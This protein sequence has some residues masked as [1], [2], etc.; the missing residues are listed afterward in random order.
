MNYQETIQY[1]YQQLPAY[2]RIGKAAYK[3]DLETTLKLDE[4]FGHPH[5]LFKTIHVAGTNGKGSTSHMIASVLQSA[6]YKVGLYTSPHLYDFRERIKINGEMITEQCVVDFVKNHKAIIDE[7]KPSF[8]EMT[9]AMAFEYFAQQK[10][11][12]AVIEVGMGGR[13]DS[14]NIIS[15]LL[16][17]ITNIGLDHTE[18]LGD[19]VEKVAAEKAGIIK[20]TTP[21]VIGEWNA[22]SATVFTQK[23]E[24]QNAP[25]LFANKD[26]LVECANI[27]DAKQTFHIKAVQPKQFSFDS[28]D[29]QIDLLGS[30]QKNNILTVLAAIEQLKKTIDIKI[31]NAALLNGLANAAQQ[32]GLQ[33]RWQ[34]LQTNPAIIADTGHNAHGLQYVMAQLKSMPYN[35]LYMV[36]GVVS[37]KDVDSILPLLPR[38]AYYFFT[39]ADLPRAMDANKLAQKCMQ[40]GLN[41]EVI[42]GVKNALLA[43]KKQANN[44]DVIFVGGSTFV[45]AEV[46]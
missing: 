42:T 39:K 27:K 16:S 18:F 46:V 7:V 21:V 41:G 13:L 44:N 34:V 40:A 31:S 29:V 45:V 32:T 10:V 35:K 30:Y 26:L 15:P 22:Q 43:A 9:V 11:D 14:T 17:V 23:A 33:G 20:H 3:A 28:I 24:Q 6:G 2:Q 1:L 4:Y 38:D 12:I 37:D 5:Q 36:L 25:I 19:T 8:F